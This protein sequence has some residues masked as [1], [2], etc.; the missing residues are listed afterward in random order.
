M[1]SP[2]AE[3]P[4]GSTRSSGTAIER[5]STAETI[6]ERDTAWEGANGDSATLT[7]GVTPVIGRNERTLTT[8]LASSTR[9]PTTPGN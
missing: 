5:Q 6:H 2:A 8:F 4:R 1:T 3:P 7:D 9:A